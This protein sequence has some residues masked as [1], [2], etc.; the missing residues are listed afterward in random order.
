LFGW[1]I[2]I[3]DGDNGVYLP[4]HQIGMPGYPNAAHHS[5]YHSPA[6]HLE[7][8]MRLLQERNA[9]GGRKE[10]RSMKA[11]LLAGKMSV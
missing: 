5:P 2:G 10:L 6:Y 9:E 8:Y 11:D 4:M 1:G 7:V 3:N